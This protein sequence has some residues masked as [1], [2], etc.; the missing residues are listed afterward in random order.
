MKKMITNFF[1][2][3]FGLILC[4]SIYAVD[5]YT[6]DLVWTGAAC[7]SAFNTTSLNWMTPTDSLTALPF[8]IG[9]KLLISNGLPNKLDTV[10]GVSITR[11][12]RY[13]L[14]KDSFELGGLVFNS[15][16]AYTFGTETYSG[17]AGN[18]LSGDFQMVQEG[19]GVITLVGKGFTLDNTQGTL[20]QNGSTLR[21]NGPGGSSSTNLIAETAF[22]PKVTFNN[23]HLLMGSASNTTS[24]T[25]GY[26]KMKWDIDVVDNSYGTLT[27]DRYCT[28]EGKM[29]GSANSTFNLNL[30]CV[31]EVFGGDASDFKGIF[32]VGMDHSSDAGT[33]TLYTAQSGFACGAFILTDTAGV[34][35]YN[36]DG[37]LHTVLPLESYPSVMNTTLYTYATKYPLGMPDATINL[38]D[39]VLMVWGSDLTTRTGE[40]TLYRDNS[41]CRI[42]ALNGTSKSLL[43]STRQGADASIHTW[44]IGSANTDAVF[45]GMILNSG[46]KYKKG[47]TNNITKVG[48]GDWRLTYSS[49]TF[50]GDVWVREG[51]LTVLGSMSTNKKLTV[52]SAATLKGSPTFTAL[53][54]SD[55]NG[56]LEIGGEASAHGL[57]TMYFGAGDINVGST[58]NIRIG[59]GQGGRCDKI[60][61][62]ALTTFDA[63]ATIEF[64]VEEG[65]VV[66]G[67]TF[68]V[69]IPISS[70]ATASILNSC[71]VVCQSGLVLDYTHLFDDPIWATERWACGVV[72]VISNTNAGVYQSLPAQVVSSTP[73]DKGTVGRSG[74]IVLTY[75]KNVARGTGSI[76][77]GGIAFEPVV[78]DK[79][80]TI[81]FS[82]LAAAADSFTLVVPGGAILESANNESATAYTATYFNDKV[83]PTLTA[84]SVA[85][86]AS[87]SWADGSMTFTFSEP[88]VVAN[89]AGITINQTQYEKV[90]PSVSSSVLTL[91]YIALNY[92]SSYTVNVAE[93][94]ITDAVGNPAAAISLSFTTQAPSTY[95]DTVGMNGRAYTYLPIDYDPILSGTTNSYPLWSY[96]NSGAGSFDET[97]GELTW[98]SNSSNNKVMCA[99]LGTASKISVSAR[100][101]GTDNVGLKIQESVAEAGASAWRTIVELDT[102]DLTTTE[103]V[104]S[105]TPTSGMRFLKILPSTASSTSSIIL[106]GYTIEGVSSLKPI[107]E[108]SIRS[109]NVDGGLSLHGLTAGSRVE[110]YNVAGIRTFTTVAQS[111]VLF[112]PVKN[113][114]IVKISDDN[115]TTALKAMVK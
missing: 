97:A 107:S 71:N 33:Y 44:Q 47:L 83:V 9:S 3:C 109:I 15:P 5:A 69:L 68:A 57:G 102:A 12:R 65:P 64:F 62:A 79:T 75:D 72:T 52:D 66:A 27:F 8:T 89:K 42:G 2:I 115:G 70:S 94:A 14:L 58:A 86:A 35:E 30:R 88:I 112:V 4:T 31:R 90:K 23:G 28:W 95:S 17:G 19:T 22:G 85:A 48:T 73:A 101:T 51:S 63:A 41:I 56:T 93:G 96:Y 100:R 92:N 29:T 37:S 103:Q 59:L 49:H 91:S 104:F 76:T 78:A 18:V 7:D 99:F 39:S 38:K 20:I 16:N 13:L 43:G 60:N 114:A 113:F 25:I 24:T 1:G 54:S 74:S 10:S 11:N 40:T 53:A 108:S 110:V 46:F 82:G 34:A 98:T 36:L 77:M 32:N 84:Q 81:N 45:N 6:P 105:Y 67:D 21:V 111:D 61:Y 80:V 87:L 55:I 50:N 106:G 26:E